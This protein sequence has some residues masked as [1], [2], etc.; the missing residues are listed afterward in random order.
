MTIAAPPDCEVRALVKT[1]LQEHDD[2]D[3]VARLLIEFARTCDHIGLERSAERFRDGA[4]Q[5]LAPG[6]QLALQG[7]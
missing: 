7:I 2:T 3:A 1:L 5:L 6:G 4:A